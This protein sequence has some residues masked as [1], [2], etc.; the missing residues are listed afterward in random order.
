MRILELLSTLGKR[1]GQDEELKA[2]LEAENVLEQDV[3]ANVADALLTGLM[4]ENAARQWAVE[5]DEVYNSTV[6]KRF[7]SHDNI[8]F[9]H[10]QSDDYRHFF[11]HDDVSSIRNEKKSS[12]KVTKA[13]D[14][15]L[16]KTSAEIARAKE[17]GRSE[18]SQEGS[19][20]EKRYQKVVEELTGKLNELKK[21]NE[22]KDVLLETQKKEFHQTRV[23]SYWTQ[24][25]AGKKFTG[26]TERTQKLQRR[27]ILEQINAEVDVRF[28]EG[29]E[30]MYFVKGTDQ[31]VLDPQNQTEATT[32]AILFK[33]GG[34][35]HFAKN[36]VEP[37]PTPQN[38][39]AVGKQSIQNLPP[40]MQKYVKANQNNVV[41]RPR[42]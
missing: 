8:L 20:V 3:P 33:Y 13:L 21:T 30:A 15:L 28:S 10:I 18:K 26:Q 25:M 6:R 36:E 5:D 11:T 37:K 38:A 31:R 42:R 4:N 19:E 16:Q 7:T 39:R 14:I 40:S 2:F 1:V 12:D 24:Q 34:K 29:G 27:D 32:E 41:Q 35:E 22:E 23:N 17:Q 9:S